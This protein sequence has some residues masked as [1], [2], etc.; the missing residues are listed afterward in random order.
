MT[1]SLPTGFDVRGSLHHDPAIKKGHHTSRWRRRFFVLAVIAILSN[2]TLLFLLA[3]SY[4]T[5]SRAFTLTKADVRTMLQLLP[6]QLTRDELRE[7]LLRLPKPAEVRE[8]KDRVTVD[9]FTFHFT[10]KGRLER[11]EHWTANQL[12]VE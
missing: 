1:D 4:Y 9:G 2:L 7:S 8:G 5:P 12:P 10:A 11:V 6:G 3:W